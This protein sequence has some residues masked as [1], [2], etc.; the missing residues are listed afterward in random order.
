M[1][2]GQ[3]AS[4]SRPNRSTVAGRTYLDLQNL[5][6]R[7]GRPTDE[8]LQLYALEGFLDRLAQSPHADRLV[9]KGGVLL[10]AYDA[11]RP[12]RDIDIAATELRASP[13]DVLQL[14]RKI[15]AVDIEDGIIYDADTAT[16]GV[17]RD[18][19]A[20]PGVRVALSA[21]LATA[22]LALHVDVN[23]GDP[24]APP[25]QLVELPRLLGGT[26][27][28]TGYPLPMV[29]AEKMIT[30]VDRG[31]LN[32][33]WRDFADIYILIGR[34]SISGDQ[35]GEAL[36]EV[37]AY[38][39][40]RISPLSEVLDGYAGSAQPR[41]AAWR[42]KQLLDDRLPATFSDVVD[43]VAGFADPAL[44][45]QVAGRSWHPEDRVWR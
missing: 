28:L 4:D 41:W 42:R 8:L 26:L 10:A 24:I 30:A 43:L 22:Q 12:T 14:V 18:T 3:G 13:E 6:R 27:T 20:Y 31:S 9:L 1:T 44:D 5:A 15:A 35:L 17:I 23:V 11:R 29:L 7:Q 19:D 45:N 21:R 34:Q 38:R 16:A 37:A 36:A 40:V 2:R 39:A 32:T 25:P 33:R